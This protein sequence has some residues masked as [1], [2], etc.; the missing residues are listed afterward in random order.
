MIYDPGV[1]YYKLF[2]CIIS[3]IDTAVDELHPFPS[4]TNTVAC[5]TVD[6][7]L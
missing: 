3:E 4:H 6:R 5:T 1:D 7:E 2:S